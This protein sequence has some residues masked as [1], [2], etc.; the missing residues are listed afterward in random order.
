MRLWWYQ[1]KNN[2]IN[3]TTIFSI[4]LVNELFGLIRPLEK[5]AVVV[6]NEDNKSVHNSVALLSCVD[7]LHL[8][9]MTDIFLKEWCGHVSCLSSS[10]L[11]LQ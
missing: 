3:L 9:D 2:N 10:S 6:N 8:K 5:Y 1:V 7:I 11:M 4:L